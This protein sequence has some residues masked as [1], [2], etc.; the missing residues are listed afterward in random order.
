MYKFNFDSVVG[1]AEY[2]SNVPN[3]VESFWLRI[4]IAVSSF[5]P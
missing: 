3:V 4:E 1:V 5:S 2:S